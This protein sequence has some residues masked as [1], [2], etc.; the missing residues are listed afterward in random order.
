MQL[1]NSRS[2]WALLALVLTVAAAGCGK[3]GESKNPDPGP[4]QPPA[5]ADKGPHDGKLYDLGRDHTHHAEL[6]FDDA[7]KT[8]T[9]YVVDQKLQETPIE[10]ETITLVMTVDGAAKTHQLKATEGSEGQWNAFQ[11][12]EE[13]YLALKNPHAQGKLRVPIGG[14][15]VLATIGGKPHTHEGDD[16]L[17]WVRRD[18]EQGEFKITL[19]HHGKHLHAG[20]DVEPAV[21]ITRDGKPVADAKVFNSL[22]SEDG[23][24]ELAP[25]KATVFEPTTDEEPAHYAQGDLSIP[26]GVTKALVRFRI[27]LPG[28]DEAITLDMPLTVEG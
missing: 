2:R 21:M 10:A 11:A 5:H 23:S 22:H 13:A 3:K 24:K 20:Q 26:K 28:S 25:E 4:Q 19:G 8:A 17:V 18:I 9:I 14:V 7:A 16:A 27:V 1:S 15:Q 6:V 12:D